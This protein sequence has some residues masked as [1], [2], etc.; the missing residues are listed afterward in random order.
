MR[1]PRVDLL[2]RLL[3]RPMVTNYSCRPDRPIGFTLD[4]D[5]TDPLIRMQSADLCPGSRLGDRRR[6]LLGSTHPSHLERRGNDVQFSR[7]QITA[8]WRPRVEHSLKQRAEA[9]RGDAE[10]LGGMRGGCATSRARRSSQCISG[11][12]FCRRASR[13]GEVVTPGQLRKRCLRNFAFG[14]RRPTAAAWGPRL[15]K[16]SRLAFRCTWG[17]GERRSGPPDK[18]RAQRER[19]AL[20]GRYW[21]V[22]RRSLITR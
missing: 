16:A 10:E 13:S 18:A 19:G 4:L 5:E 9:A 17:G 11:V 15:G 22:P 20:E 21:I 8:S 1:A 12:R 6:D 3:D 14:P 7:P 2:Q